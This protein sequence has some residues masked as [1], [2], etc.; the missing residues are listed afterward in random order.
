MGLSVDLTVPTKS[1]FDLRLSITDTSHVEEG[2]C[3]LCQK[4]WIISDLEMVIS[5]TRN[6]RSCGF[7]CQFVPL[8]VYFLVRL[9]ITNIFKTNYQAVTT[10]A[11]HIQPPRGRNLL[12][13]VTSWLNLQCQTA[14][15]RKMT[16]LINTKTGSGVTFLQH[17]NTAQLCHFNLQKLSYR[18][19]TWS[20]DRHTSICF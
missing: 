5:F 15:P 17:S 18:R 9:P 14:L 7:F 11:V 16:A 4:V 13:L 1:H 3:N 6:L 2:F 12:I 20:V 8:F 10:F 19:K